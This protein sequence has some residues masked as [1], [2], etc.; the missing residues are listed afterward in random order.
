MTNKKNP[1]N[2]ERLIGEYREKYELY[3]DFCSKVAAI[4]DQVV[5]DN[6]YKYQI[7]THRAKKLASA[8]MRFQSKDS[9][10]LSDL[11]DLAGCRVI[12][13]LESDIN[14]FIGNIYDTFGRDNI[15]DHDNKINKD[16]YNAVHIVIKLGEDRLVHAEYRRYK[17]LICEIQLTTVLHHAWSEMEHDL[18]YKPTE[19]LTVFDSKAFDAIREGFKKTM[20]NHIQPAM[21]DFEY[22][23]QE[24]KKLNEG[25][26]VFNLDFLNRIETAKSLNELQDDLKLLEQYVHEFGDKTPRE[27]PLIVLLK[28]IIDKAKIFKPEPI[29]SAL[30]NFRGATYEDIVVIILSIL[31]TMR[32]WYTEDVCDIC[33]NIL[34]HEKNKQILD[35]TISV[36]NH[37]S[38]Y[39]T[40]ILNSVGRYHPQEQVLKFLPTVILQKNS[41]TKTTIAS[42][43]KE[44][45]TLSFH[46]V[47]SSDYKT[48]TFQPTFLTATPKLKNIRQQA[49]NLLQDLY[50]NTKDLK[51]KLG[52]IKVFEYSLWKD[53][54]GEIKDPEDINKLIKRDAKNIIAFYATLIKNEPSE[55]IYVIEKHLM[56]L[57]RNL[58]QKIPQ[59]EELLSTISSNVDYQFFKIFVGYDTDFYFD[60]NFEKAKLYRDTKINEFLADV[61]RK[62]LRK[63]KVT[64]KKVTKNYEHSGQG[65]YQYFNFFLFELAKQKPEIAI[66]LIGER[67]LKPFLIHLVAGI[68][69]SKNK[70]LAKTL[71]DK[72][73]DSYK[74]F[75]VC[76]TIF[77]YV[78]EIDVNL[79]KKT[80]TKAIEK[81][82]IAA[83]NALISAICRNET[84]EPWQKAIFFKII[85]FLTE[86][87]ETSWTNHVW[88]RKS[89][90]I[91]NLTKLESKILLQN[92]ILRDNIS[93][94]TEEILKSV[95]TKYPK[96]FIN[97]LLE[98]VHKSAKIKNRLDRFSQYDA[99]PHRL[100]NI[101]EPLQKNADIVIPELLRW[102]SMGTAKTDQWLYRWEASHLL[103]DVFPN[104]DPRLEKELIKLIR[105]GGKEAMIVVDEF[106]SRF[107]G[108]E[109]LWKLVEE[110]VKTFKESSKYTE[111]KRK[112][113]GYLSQTGVVVGE[114]GFVEAFKNKK[115]A[116]TTLKDAANNDYLKFLN[117]YESH[118]DKQIVAYE[119]MADDEI[120]KRK[121]EYGS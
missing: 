44:V 108:Q 88:F 24:Y 49:Y 120:D 117:E 31:D 6:N 43:L 8:S 42:M 119:K 68:W 110:L 9:G 53:D 86:L 87:G 76:A 32:Y 104:S 12:F 45:L 14:K 11:K 33:F 80:V 114:Y 10:N 93:H 66:L 30:G 115:I 63:W 51:E 82:N 79:F 106:I 83:L 23:F 112:L 5:K 7:I 21:R 59:T 90:I 75:I 70:V 69:K 27:L 107:E 52:I 92:L 111:I 54:Y 102:Y 116:L 101:K 46:G 105:A 72:W 96:E 25:Y 50:V 3:S 118:L 2:Y 91:K 84:P 4:L 19:E 17:D 20:L 81:K 97:F 65:T 95:A 73:C 57:Q 64:L 67:H 60:A 18:V 36:L 15:V 29:R 56:L 55:I 47:N 28:E 62:T 98:R 89:S 61:S 121:R 74:N 109:F 16:G 48:I 94:E 77:D 41:V 13:Y 58:N 85:R 99:I 71:L 1:N 78:E 35:K 22:L 34:K 38:K 39:D 100:Y 113:F 103:K 37:L 40:R 26:G